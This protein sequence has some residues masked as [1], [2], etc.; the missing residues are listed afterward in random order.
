MSE[1]GAAAGRRLASAL[2]RTGWSVRVRGADLVPATGGVVLAANHVNFLDGPLL[3]AVAP[4]PVHCLSKR[5]LFRGPVGW[6]LRGTGQ[7]PVDREGPDRE[8]V[9]AALGVLRAGQVLGMFPEGTRG[10]GEFET[11]RRGVAYFALRT[12]APVVPVVCLGVGSRGRTLGSLPP[13]RSRLDVIFGAPFDVVDAGLRGSAR[14]AAASEQVRTALVA[15]LAA[16]RSAVP[17]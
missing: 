10:S 2:V 9:S 16:A 13:P 5:E 7:I 11:I 17:D 15:H 4:R 12:G 3:L 14:L 1:R 8:A 6:V